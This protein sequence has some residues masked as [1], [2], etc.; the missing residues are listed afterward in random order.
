MISIKLLLNNIIKRNDINTND[1]NDLFK[2][3]DTINNFIINLLNENINKDNKS[4]KETI[5]NSIV[6]I[7]NKLNNDYINSL[8]NIDFL[9]LWIDS[10]LTY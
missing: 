2:N 4:M 9:R 7:K 8:N 10:Y 6:F 5:N 3:I 1:K